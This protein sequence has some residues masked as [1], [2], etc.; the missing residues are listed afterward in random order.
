MPEHGFDFSGGAFTLYPGGEDDDA[1]GEVATV[2]D[3]EEVA[4]GGSC[5]G[6][7]DGD[8]AGQ[9]GQQLFAS[10][11][12]EAF[13]LELLLELL[14]AFLEAAKPGLQGDLGDELVAA[15]GFIHADVSEQE[16]FHAC[17]D[18]EVLSGGVAGEEHAGQLAAGILEGEVDVAGALTPEI[19][20]FSL[21]PESGEAVF[22]GGLDPS[23]QVG[24][25][26]HVGRFR[27]EPFIHHG[28]GSV[29]G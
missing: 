23:G 8:A 17:L 5:G 7:D 13:A 19:G 1:P 12:E 11:V 16:E 27:P 3:A 22:Q 4:E 15:V 24:H 18:G 25:L 2:E 26:E 28:S 21:H 14:E 10:G 29:C 20:D 9:E 6:G